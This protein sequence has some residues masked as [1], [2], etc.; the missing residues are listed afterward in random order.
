M[1]LGQPARARPPPLATDDGEIVSTAEV[2]T[3][4]GG[5]F[6]EHQVADFQPRPDHSQDIF[7][8]AKPSQSDSGKVRTP[9]AG[10]RGL[11]RITVTVQ[12]AS[13]QTFPEISNATDH[14]L[15]VTA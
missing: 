1:A 10:F 11:P 15:Q 6:L 8:L 3:S 9:L 7:I 4:L 14:E 12:R 5:T 13:Y 2:Y